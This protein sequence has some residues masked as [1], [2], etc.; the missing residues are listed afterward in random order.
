MGSVVSETTRDVFFYGLFMEEGILRGKGVNPLRPRRAVVP[1]YRLRIGRR[2][3]LVRQL[4]AQAFG[5]VFALTD[6][7]IAS[8]YAEPGLDLYLPQAVTASLEDGTFAVVTTFNLGEEHATAERNSEY[9]EKLRAV[10]E[11]LGFPTDEL[12]SIG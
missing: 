6:R 7:E 2:A 3:L 9:A 5:M 11:R 1:G 4:G 10:F 8:L 12:R